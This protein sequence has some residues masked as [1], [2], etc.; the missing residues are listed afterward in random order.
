MLFADRV[1]VIRGPVYASPFM[2]KRST[3]PDDLLRQLREHSQCQAYSPT[4]L[5]KHGHSEI[6][7]ALV[8]GNSASGRGLFAR[9]T[10]AL[11]MIEECLFIDMK[12]RRSSASIEFVWASTQTNL[13]ISWLLLRRTSRQAR[14]VGTVL[15]VPPPSCVLAS[16][17][18]AKTQY[19]S[20]CG[21]KFDGDAIWGNHVHC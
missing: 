5:A 9:F 14:Q 16:Y 7:D 10:V 21:S 8:C 1:L 3:S 11:A 2:P 19:S 15:D 20:T 12:K 4:G 6:E 13:I 18:A 17:C